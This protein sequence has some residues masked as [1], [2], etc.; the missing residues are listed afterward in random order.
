MNKKCNDTLE[1]LAEEYDKKVNI[2]LIKKT[3]NLFNLVS[4]FVISNKLILYGGFAL[5]ISLPENNKIYDDSTMNDFDCFSK[6]AKQ[7]AK[8]LSNILARNNFKYI[9]V[10]PGI[11]PGTWKVFVEF[12]SVCDITD[13]KPKQYEQMIELIKFENKEI[14]TSHQFYVAPKSFLKRELCYELSQ[15]A[16][17]SFRWTKLMNRFIKFKKSFPDK[18]PKKIKQ[19][20]PRTDKTLN[21]I[22]LNILKMCKELNV[23]FIGN[24]AIDLHKDLYRESKTNLNLYSEYD[25]FIDVI[26]LEPNQIIKNIQQMYP[27]IFKII[28]K[29]NRIILTK[30]GINILSIYNPNNSCFSYCKKKGIRVG[31]V[32]TILYFLYYEYMNR[33]LE[34][35]DDIVQNID[36]VYKIMKNMSCE[37]HCFMN[38]ICYGEVKDMRQIRKDSWNKKLSKYRPNNNKKMYSLF[39]TEIYQ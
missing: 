27:D 35:T 19:I 15:P 3:T 6:T 16:T 29:D 8:E 1:R 9:E 18:P 28:K 23:I 34:Y 24:I 36:I 22:I 11:H 12:I 13:I 33:Q 26:Y 4:D 7:H 10:K 2:N 30:D 38:I 21:E 20:Y 37:N 17:S 25:C 5:N 32:F 31:T 39:D 14:K